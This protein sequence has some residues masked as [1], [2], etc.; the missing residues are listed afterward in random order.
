MLSLFIYVEILCS[1]YFHVNNTL[2]WKD[3]CLQ[4]FFNLEIKLK[5]RKLMSTIFFGTT[6]SSNLWYFFYFIVFFFCF[7][8]L[9]QNITWTRFLHLMVD[10]LVD[11][12][13]PL[14]LHISINL[15]RVPDVVFPCSV[16]L[17]NWKIMF[18]MLLLGF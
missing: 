18:K 15:H 13:L 10:K 11:R 2:Y 14:R 12:H 16:H 7:T 6:V 3:H 8:F 1:C 4:I 17:E 5:Q 9:F